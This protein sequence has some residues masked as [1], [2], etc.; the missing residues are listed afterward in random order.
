MPIGTPM[1]MPIGMGTD[2]DAYENADR[3][4]GDAYR[5]AYWKEEG[6]L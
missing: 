4:K 3:R 1:G 2:G 6:C 5:D